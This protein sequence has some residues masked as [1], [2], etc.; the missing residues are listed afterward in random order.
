VA[1]FWVHLFEQNEYFFS[2]GF[3]RWMMTDEDIAASMRH[4]FPNRGSAVLRD[5]IRVRGRYNRGA[6][7]S[8]RRALP[9]L[10]SYRYAQYGPELWK[11]ITSRGKALPDEGQVP[12][13]LTPEEEDRITGANSVPLENTK[14]PKEIPS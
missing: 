4:A 8:Q 3:W 5:V 1:E 6:L 10:R 2:K 11:R 12:H 9:R 13:A 14:D 7:A